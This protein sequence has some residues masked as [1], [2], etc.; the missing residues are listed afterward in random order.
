[1]IIYTEFFVYI[2]NILIL[3]I[4]S[5][6]VRRH[7]YK[8]DFSVNNCRNGVL[9]YSPSAKQIRCKWHFKNWFHNNYMITI[10]NILYIIEIYLKLVRSCGNKGLPKEK[11]YL[12]NP[13][14]RC[15]AEHDDCLN[16]IKARSTCP[17]TG[18]LNPTNNDM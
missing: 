7:A 3:T 4:L 13:L 14:D 2:P 8:F 1:M 17:R 16:R 10:S 18:V 12:L 11:Y 9:F 15:C 6:K 5:N